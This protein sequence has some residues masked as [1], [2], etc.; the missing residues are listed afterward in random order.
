MDL[1]K[2]IKQQFPEV[3]KVTSIGKSLE[4]RDISLLT[5]GIDIDSKE[6]K[7]KDKNPPSVFITSVHH[8]REVVT[9]SMNFY[10]MLQLLHGYVHKDVSATELLRMHN[11]YSV[12]MLNVDSYALISET[13]ASTN[14]FLFLRKNRR[15]EGAG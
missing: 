8:A 6:M 10:I 7:C 2:E 1:L 15:D 12:P 5:L 9:V 11:F 3:S 14:R 4:N 13:W